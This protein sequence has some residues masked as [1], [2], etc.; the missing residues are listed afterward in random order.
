MGSAYAIKEEERRKK[1][2]TSVTHDTHTLSCI[3]AVSMGLSLMC[4][5]TQLAVK[6]LTGS[7]V[8]LAVSLVDTIL[9]DDALFLFTRETDL[10]GSVSATLTAE[11]PENPL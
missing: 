8:V 2:N 6:G 4:L 1:K 10:L 7:F 5:R 3:R 9:F 11:R